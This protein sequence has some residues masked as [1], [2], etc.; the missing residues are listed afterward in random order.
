MG[1]ARL[2]GTLLGT[3]PQGKEKEALKRTF[4]RHYELHCS[5][6]PDPLKSAEQIDYRQVH[7]E[8]FRALP[9]LGS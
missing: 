7:Q 3:F 8:G 5:S 6:G 9:S 2:G 4:T 1:E